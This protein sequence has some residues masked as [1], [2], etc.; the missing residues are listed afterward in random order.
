MVYAIARPV[1]T[2]NALNTKGAHSRRFRGQVFLKFV[3]KKFFARRNERRIFFVF[4]SLLFPLF[5]NPCLLFLIGIHISLC[6]SLSF[7]LCCLFEPKRR[8]SPAYFFSYFLII[9]LVF[10]R[11]NQENHPPNLE[12]L[13]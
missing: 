11:T 13:H 5:S 1:R 8:L 10:Q 7:S 2:L 12:P 6:F 4:L 3:D 9:R